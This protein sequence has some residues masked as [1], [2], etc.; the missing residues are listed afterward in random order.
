MIKTQ[1]KVRCI[2]NLRCFQQCSGWICLAL[3]HSTPTKCLSSESRLCY[4]M[5]CSAFTV[6]FSALDFGKQRPLMFSY[7]HSSACL[8]QTN[9][10]FYCILLECLILKIVVWGLRDS[11]VKCFP[12]KHEDLTS[13]LRTHI[14]MSDTVNL[15]THCYGIETRESLGLAS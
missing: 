7:Y 3:Q 15:L 10:S 1:F 14:K 8:F 12:C 6:Q 4:I 5:D 13:V 11:S 9:I 2:M